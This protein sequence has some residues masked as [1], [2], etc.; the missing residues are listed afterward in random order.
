[1]QS[2]IVDDAGFPNLAKL[3]GQVLAVWPEHRRYLEKSIGARDA[4]LMQ[5]S[6]LLASMVVRLAGEMPG[7]L[8]N[9]CADYRFLC[10]GIVLPEELHFRRHGSY[11]LTRFEDA[12]RTVYSDRAFMT[13]YMTGLLASDVLWINHCQGLYHYAN[14]FLGGLRP[15]S[16]LLEIGPGHGLLLYLATRS[17]NVGQVTAW[18]ISKASL[19]MTQHALDVLQAPRAARFEEKNIFEPSIMAPENGGM[20][21]A[22][23]LSEVLEH[24]EQPE[25]A[26]RVLF[27]LCRPGGRVWI[28]VPANSPA[29]DH[30]Y[31]VNEPDEAKRLVSDAGFKVVD[32]ANFPMTGVTLDR[33]IRQ[34]LTITCIIVGER[35]A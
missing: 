13:R 32:V 1:M 30:L 14:D 35:P 9:L 12:L 2:I 26:V 25:Q 28:N 16:S 34:K 8:P 27:H 22:V 15:G 24:L 20:F 19:E 33:A 4:A 18:D 10:E 21:D 3:V 29:P 31:L 7:G 11:R 23:V 6:E 17:A 5:H